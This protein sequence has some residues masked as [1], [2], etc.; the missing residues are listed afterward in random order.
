M[1][2]FIARQQQRREYNA[3]L[4]T[5]V[6]KARAQI[7]AGQFASSAEVG[8][9]AAARRKALGPRAGIAKKQRLAG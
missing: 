3:F 5:K 9:R 6:D 2:E 1:R 8:K 4:R 7:A